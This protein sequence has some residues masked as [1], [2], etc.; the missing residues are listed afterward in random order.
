VFN[1]AQFFLFLNHQLLLLIL[2][3][4]GYYSKV[5]Q[6]FSNYL[7]GRKTW[8]SWNN[9][10]SQFFNVDVGVKQGLALSS[11]LSAIYI[12]PAFHILKNWLKN[13]KIPISI[14]L[15]TIVYPLLRVNL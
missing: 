1:I 6:F 10:S 4:A 13:L 7:V 2:K 5:V 11:I 15:L 8:Y 9:F 14:L 12:A 3:K